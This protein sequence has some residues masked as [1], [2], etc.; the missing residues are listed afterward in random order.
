[1]D[2]IIARVS[3]KYS[4]FEIFRIKNIIIIELVIFEKYESKYD[5]IYFMWLN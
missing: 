4:R 3:A 5:Q 1:M 2:I